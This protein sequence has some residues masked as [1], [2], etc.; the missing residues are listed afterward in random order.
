MEPG[1]STKSLG[2]EFSRFPL[3]RGV[4]VEIA[5]PDAYLFENGTYARKSDCDISFPSLQLFR[6]QVAESIEVQENQGKDSNVSSEQARTGDVFASEKAGP[7]PQLMAL[8]GSGCQVLPN[9]HP[10]AAAVLR[11]TLPIHLSIPLVALP[12]VTGLTMLA[13][14]LRKLTT[15]ASPR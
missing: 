14:L 13:D 2:L 10:I 9:H 11:P 5:E 1:R 12:C 4:P 8:A 3:Y 7:P 15:C 6:V